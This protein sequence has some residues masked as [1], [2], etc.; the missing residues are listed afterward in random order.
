MSTRVLFVDDEVRV[1][2]GVCRLLRRNRDE[3]HASVA[4]G[5][6]IAL[7]MLDLERFDCVV[8]DMRMPSIDGAQL[9]AGVRARHPGTVRMVLS[10]QTELEA[11]LRAAL[12][13]HQ[14]LSKPCGSTSLI[15]ALE[16]ARRALERTEDRWLRERVVGVGMLPTARAAHAAAMTVVDSQK[17]SLDELARIVSSDLGIQ[18]KLR[19]VVASSFF[20]SGRPPQSDGEVVGLFGPKLLKSLLELMTDHITDDVPEHSRRSDV[21]LAVRAGH[22]VLWGAGARVDDASAR[23]AG[24]MLLAL[25]GIP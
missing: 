12:L 8:S 25:W 24:E 7:S 23:T 14:F 19:Q 3:W 17:P 22:L 10:G 18:L 15:G 1:L 21:D 13:A 16:R 5:G 4:L 2:D 11:S 20:G 9:L 6:D